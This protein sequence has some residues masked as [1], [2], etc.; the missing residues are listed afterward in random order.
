[1]TIN[2]SNPLINW[3]CLVQ[4]NG[5]TSVVMPDDSIYVIEGT[6]ANATARYVRG[7]NSEFGDFVERQWSS[8]M[9]NDDIIGLAQE[10]LDRE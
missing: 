1:M 8:G 10:W 3:P 5:A 7:P 4:M 9:T 2:R 6:T